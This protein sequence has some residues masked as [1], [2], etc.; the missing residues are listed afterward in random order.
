MIS[1]ATPEN[2]MST[3]RKSKRYLYIAAALVVILLVF[4]AVALKLTAPRSIKIH[5]P[6][7]TDYLHRM[8][9]VS[10]A[11]I[12]IVRL[13]RGRIQLTIGHE[14]IQ[15]VTPEMIVWWFKNFPEKKIKV[16]GRV[17]PWYWL[18][19]PIDH[20]KVVVIEKEKPG[21]NGATISPLIEIHEQMGPGRFMINRGRAD[22][23][24]ASGT[25][26]SFKLGP[27]DA[28]FLEHVFTR[29]PDGTRIDT[30]MALGLN[31]PVLSHYINFLMRTM[32]ADEPFLR[33]M[34]KHIVEEM[35][36]FQFFLPRLYA[37]QNRPAR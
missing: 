14:T 34:I 20:V 29:V 22:K 30:R 5:P 25:R 24:D 8:K 27:I 16:N 9:K 15:G 6:L 26:V 18:W 36:N 7:Q 4:P 32:T 28:G 2:N 33:A 31:M 13:D 23:M 17:V 35:G 12:K 1:F 21:P 3:N 37:E 11:K 10:S 19:H